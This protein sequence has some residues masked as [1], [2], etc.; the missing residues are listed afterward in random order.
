MSIQTL[1]DTGN[2]FPIQA[3]YDGA[4]YSL[5]GGDF[6]IDGIGDEFTMTYSANSLYVTFAEGSQA[7]LDGNF[8]RTTSSTS[9]QLSAN[10]TT[11]L[12]A[13]INRTA[14]AGNTGQFAKLSSESSMRSDNLNNSQT[15]IRDLL[16]Y[17]IVT[18]PSGVTQVTDRRV[19]RP[20]GIPARTFS[21]K[22]VNFTPAAATQEA[23]DSNYEYKYYYNITF[24]GVTSL[25]IVETFVAPTALLS[26]MAPYVQTSTNHIKIWLRDGAQVQCT[27]PLVITRP[28]R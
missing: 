26:R 25:D 3:S 5:I 23:W 12:C 18:G 27:L 13:R 1:Q 11:Y 10:T 24:S 6:V 4:V 16:L 21:D 17:V 19:I 22:S 9:V 15:A 8:F 28:Y 2:S 20:A 7:I 14:T